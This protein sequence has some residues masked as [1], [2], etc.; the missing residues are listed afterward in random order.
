MKKLITILFIFMIFYISLIGCS[1]KGAQVNNT[2]EDKI[3][4]AV[5]VES[6]GN[7]L[8]QVSLLAPPED[9]KK[10]ME[11]NYGRYLTS[12]LLAEFLNDP[13]NAPGRLTSSPWPDR[14]EITST[15]KTSEGLYKVA[16]T[17][18]EVTSTEQ[19]T[20]NAA[21]KRPIT[22]DVKKVDGKW[23][24]S[25]V[26]LGVYE[27]GSQ[28]VY[29]NRG[30]GFTFTLPENWSGY[31]IVA[32]AW[33]GR[34]VGGSTSG[35]I[36]ETGP[37]FLI[38]HP[39]WTKENPREDIPVMVFTLAQWDKVLQE[40]ISLGAAPIGPTELGRNSTYV[41]ALPARYNFDFLT[42]YQEIEQILAENPLKPF[43]L[44]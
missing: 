13:D 3:A 37:K 36:T 8:Q 38:R 24:I 29:M 41:F 18:I 35:Q 4:V 16:G 34:S 32:E 44:Q 7:K 2:E 15:E 20:E 31:T 19:G 5:L 21:A 33:E 12:E 11:D 10:S 17:I 30:Y 27:A 39:E 6:F 43:N 42:G 25:S 28:I 1:E 23:L 40:N 26:V 22:L 14:I 9:L